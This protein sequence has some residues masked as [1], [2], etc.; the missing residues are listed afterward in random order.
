MERGHV[1][2]RRGVSWSPGGLRKPLQLKE[3]LSESDENT[4]W[5]RRGFSKEHI[6]RK[7]SKCLFVL[8]FLLI[9]GLPK[10]RKENNSSYFQ[11]QNHS[12]VMSR[13]LSAA[14]VV[15]VCGL[16]EAPYFRKSCSD[17]WGE[18]GSPGLRCDTLMSS[19]KHLLLCLERTSCPKQQWWCDQPQLTKGLI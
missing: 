13:G 7:T 9:P 1:S 14:F 4:S 5:E 17:C 15:I 2:V 6:S 19:M 8:H 3:D 16:D 11:T 18:Q 10:L 12:C